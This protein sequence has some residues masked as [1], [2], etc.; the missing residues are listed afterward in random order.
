[1]KMTLIERFRSLSQEPFSSVRKMGVVGGQR[2]ADLGSGQ[3][4]F[5]IPAALAVGRGGFVYSI[6]PDQRRSDRIRARIATEGLDNVRVLTARVENLGDI[7]SGDVDLAFSVF[8]LHHFEDRN[9]ALAEVRRILRD[10]GTF[11]VWDRTPRRIFKWGTQP[12][13]LAQIAQ[14]FARFESLGTRNTIRARFTK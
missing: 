6:E 14:G 12:E 3:G 2:V 13:E 1:M 9:T 5:T 8:S 10:G 7:P 4:Y 11:Y